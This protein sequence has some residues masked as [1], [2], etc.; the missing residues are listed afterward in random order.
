MKTRVFATWLL[1]HSVMAVAQTV[2]YDFN[3]IGN[4]LVAIDS[5]PETMRRKWDLE[6]EE[7]IKGSS[8]DHETLYAIALDSQDQR[9][10]RAIMALSSLGTERAADIL[11]SI[12]RGTDEVAAS[13]ARKSLAGMPTGIAAPRLISLL[14]DPALQKNRKVIISYLSQHPCIDTEEALASAAK[15]SEIQTHALSALGLVGTSKSLELLKRYSDEGVSSTVRSISKHSIRRIEQ[16]MASCKQGVDPEYEHYFHSSTNADM[17]SIDA[18]PENVTQTLK[19]PANKQQE[20]SSVEAIGANLA[21]IER[22][23]L[24]AENVKNAIII[25]NHTFHAKLLE[26][27]TQAGLVVLNEQQKEVLKGKALET[28]E[29]KQANEHVREVLLDTMMEI[30]PGTMQMIESLGIHIVNYLQTYDSP[31]PQPLEP[32]KGS[33]EVSH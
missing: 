2:A 19:L 28:P 7:L 1:L 4:R 33:K 30:N 14:E 15:N 3:N 23:A 13:I 31:D 18:K 12:A 6:L 24:Q 17:V 16:R 32:E 11:A 10:G 9:S 20:L 25:F 21:L 29:V 5:E 27:E 8:V 26:Y 22:Q